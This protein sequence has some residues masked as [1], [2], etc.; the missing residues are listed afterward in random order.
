MGPPELPWLAFRAQAAEVERRGFRKW[1]SRNLCAHNAAAVCRRAASFTMGVLFRTWGQYSRRPAGLRGWLLEASAL[2]RAASAT[3]GPRT[4]KRYV[5]ARNRKDEEIAKLRLWL[6]KHHTL[7]EGNLPGLEPCQGW[8]PDPPPPAPPPTPPPHPL[9]LPPVL[10][11][12]ASPRPARAKTPPAKTLKKSVFHC[13]AQGH[14]P[15]P[16]KN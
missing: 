11:R 2:S 5:T 14:Q 15:G 4:S 6:L 1:W 13:P 8:S 3:N 16:Y 10:P 7:Q 12:L 9:A